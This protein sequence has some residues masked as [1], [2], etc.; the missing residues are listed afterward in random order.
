MPTNW[1]AAVVGAGPAG[2][3][4]AALLARRGWRVLLLD[5]ARFPR[6]KVCGEYL[7]GAVWPVLGDLGV[8]GAVRQ[9]AVPLDRLCLVL[10]GGQAIAAPFAG[11]AEQRPAALSRYALDELLVRRAVACGAEL[12]EGYRVTSVGIEGGRAVS[13]RAVSVDHASA[14]LDVSADWIIA[15]D[16]RRSIVVRQTGSLVRR[17]HGLVGFKRHFIRQ[18]NQPP[19]GALEMHSFAGGY[20]GVGPVE[21]GAWNVCGVMPRRRVREAR[22]SIDTAWQQWIG[23]QTPLAGLLRGAE[24][25]DGW[26]SVPE[27]ATQTAAPRVAGVLYVGDACGTI[28]PLAGQGMT[29]ALAAAALAEA[30]LAAGGASAGLDY[31]AAWQRRF[32]KHVRR[33]EWVAGLLRRPRLLAALLPLDWLAH[34]AASAA[35]AGGY[36]AISLE[37]AGGK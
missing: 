10:P 22:G 25:I 7:S 30:C 21:G 6:Q 1:D 3:T 34:R 18:E 15:A 33:A 11:P 19:A 35:L 36:R 8:A 20:V 16:G 17:R 31:S 14:P 37:T 26:L 5:A 32:G 13:L 28:E 27:V 29:M 2:S 9:A 4:L 23:S 12:R 24:P